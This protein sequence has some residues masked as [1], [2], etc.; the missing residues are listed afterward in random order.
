MS[1]G[2][3][4]TLHRYPYLSCFC[5]GGPWGQGAEHKDLYS[6]YRG[7]FNMP[8][9]LC[10]QPILVPALNPTNVLKTLSSDSNQTSFQVLLPGPTALDLGKPGQREQV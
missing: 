10:Q 8:I 3:A 2:K 5:P 4:G 7:A 6:S 1:L 9:R